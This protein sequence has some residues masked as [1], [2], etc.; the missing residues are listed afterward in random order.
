MQRLQRWM[1]MCG[2]AAVV[3]GALIALSIATPHTP[4]ASSAITT[5]TSN[6]TQVGIKEADATRAVVRAANSLTVSI[7]K[8]KAETTGVLASSYAAI[9]RSRAAVV[10]EQR[11]ITA[12]AQQLSARAAALAKEGVTLQREATSLK[13]AQARSGAAS[14]NTSQGGGSQSS[15][16]GGR[17]DN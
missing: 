4:K 8:A 6:A 15:G 13:A 2:G 3:L 16:G 14:S 11:Q 9:A 10:T 17:Y 7:A 1:A 12:E 5:A